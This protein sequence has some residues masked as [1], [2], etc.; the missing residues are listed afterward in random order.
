MSKE[1]I[2]KKYLKQMR[3]AK[4]P[5]VSDEELDKTVKDPE[6]RFMLD[7]MQEYTDLQIQEL[8]ERVKELEFRLKQEIGATDFAV[9]E[10]EE[11]QS[12]YNALVEENRW[13]KPEEK[14]PE[15]CDSVLL[16]VDDNIFKIA[17]CINCKWTILTTDGWSTPEKCGLKAIS[18]RYLPKPDNT[19][20]KNK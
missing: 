17:M 11:L 15:N 8:R 19:K 2:L 20:T 13:Y 9:K 6:M 14:L 1:E 10:N 4:N 3:I 18:W 7:A 12:K 5:P 16:Q